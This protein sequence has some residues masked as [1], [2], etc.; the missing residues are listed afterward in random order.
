MTNSGGPGSFFN[1]SDIS[2]VG[3]EMF[4]PVETEHSAWLILASIFAIISLADLLL[5][6]LR[7]RSRA[8][9]DVESLAAIAIATLPHHDQSST[10]IDDDR[11]DPW[12]PGAHTDPSMGIRRRIRHQQEG[13]DEISIEDQSV[14][15]EDLPYSMARYLNQPQRHGAIGEMPFLS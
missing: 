5:N 10:I 9:Y 2:V 1:L 12:F 13:Q 15:E 7:Q 6:L 3:T 11:P 8:K 14:G 4:L